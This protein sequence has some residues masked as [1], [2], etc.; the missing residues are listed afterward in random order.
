MEILLKIILSLLAI[1]S[2]FSIYTVLMDYKK[3][4]QIE[5]YDI[6]PLWEKMKFH[7]KTFFMLFSMISIICL[8]ILYIISKITVTTF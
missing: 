5:G 6:I 2:G 8:M 4:K 7:V 1:A 3:T